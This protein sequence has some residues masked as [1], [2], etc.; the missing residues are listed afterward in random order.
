MTS[1]SNRSKSRLRPV[2]P[3]PEATPPACSASSPKRT[4]R[5][6]VVLR[7]WPVDEP[8]VDIIEGLAVTSIERTVADLV[9]ERE[10]PSLVGGFV[11]GA[12]GR[13]HV[14]DKPRLAELLSPLAA[15]NGFAK[16]DG[17]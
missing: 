8:D 6:G 11:A 3:F 2:N 7:P 9:R 13:G 5:A 16:G 1:R 4:V 14:V 17:G 10:D 12:C 15:R